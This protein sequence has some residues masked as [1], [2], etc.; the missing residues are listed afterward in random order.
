MS[1]TFSLRTSRVVKTLAIAGPLVL[2]LAACGA[3]SPTPE[4]VPQDF[5]GEQ[6]R[7]I[8]PASAGGSMDTMIRQVQPF[9]SEELGVP[10][11]VENMPSDGAVIGTQHVLDNGA[12]CLT[13]LTTNTPHLNMSYMTGNLDA[14]LADFAPVAGV[15]IE[16]GVIRVRND[17]PWETLQDLI[18]DAIER[19]GEISFSISDLTSSNYIGL[20]QIEEETGAE[21]KFVTY[22]GGGPAR[23]AVL[24][25][26]VNATHAGVF[27]SLAIAED[28][29]ILAVHETENLWGSVTD[30]AP[31]VNEAL[32][33]DLPGQ[34]SHPSVVAAAGCA[35]DYPDRYELL[36]QAFADVIASDE[37]LAA[38]EALGEDGREFY[39]NPEELGAYLQQTEEEITALLEANPDVFSG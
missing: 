10:V 15:T 12:D 25:G 37:Y 16:P 1:T 27:N 11:V 20:V 30:D 35:A 4:D 22:D 13:I 24:S 36:V 23:L 33:V 28:T 9:L 18:D 6:L 26:E 5:S 32:D 29:R 21:F 38:L 2:I 39:M 3:Q 8:V 17:A 34:S 19:P 7:I 31:T 14:E